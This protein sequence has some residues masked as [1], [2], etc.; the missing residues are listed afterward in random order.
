[1]KASLGTMAD[2]LLRDPITQLTA[3]DLDGLFH[4]PHRLDCNSAWF[5]HVPFADWLIESTR[6]GRLVELGTHNGVSYAAFCQAI[7][8]LDLPTRCVAV[9]TWQGDE[10]A[11]RYEESV[12]T[13]LAAYNAQ[14]FGAFSELFRGT[15]DEALAR[16]A[17]GSVDLLHLDGLHTYEA[18]KHDF[19]AWLPKLSDRA[20]VLFHD[21]AERREG[22]GVWSLWSELAARWPSFEFTHSHG[23]GILC[24]GRQ[25]PPAVLALAVM[26][27][28]MADRV[29]S[30]FEFL[31]AR[32]DLD[33]RIRKLR[34][35]M[36]A[37]EA[38]TAALEAEVAALRQALAAE[39]AG[40]DET[41]QG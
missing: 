33:Y 35:E 26:A 21:T 10:H 20:V 17:D 19:E 13:D 16:F 37:R 18:V 25:A 34:R 27:P 24:V 8:R 23:L 28:A 14:H 4:I 22:F 40:P 32:W 15:F 3:P 6:P 9:D 38:K 2:V 36:V 30:R 1:M 29:R 5:G 31:G 41:S 12:F 39:G 11:G 7:R